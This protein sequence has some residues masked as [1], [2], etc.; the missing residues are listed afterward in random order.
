MRR[1]TTREIH[2]LLITIMDEIHRV[3]KKNSINYYM[4]YGTALG[5]ARV[6]GFIPWD[7]DMDLGMLRPDFEKFKRIFNEDSNVDKFFLQTYESDVDYVKPVMRVCLNG[8]YMPV[9]PHLSH[10]KMNK[11][12]YIDIFPLDNIADSEAER[13]KQVNKILRCK[14]I[15]KAQ[16]S[17]ISQNDSFFIKLKKRLSAFYYSNFYPQKK[18]YRSM[19]IEMQ[20]FNDSNTK[21]I[22]SLTLCYGEKR[23]TLKRYY[24]GKPTLRPFENREY[25]FPENMEDY[26][27][28]VYGKDY[29]KVPP[30][31]L[32]RKT[33]AVYAEDVL[34]PYVVGF[35]SI[36]INS[37]TAGMLSEL[38]SLSERCDHLYVGVKSSTKE[39]DNLMDTI[40]LTNNLSFVYKAVFQKGNDVM[41][42]WDRLHYQVLFLSEKDNLPSDMLDG[43]KGRSVKIENY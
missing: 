3:C 12:F 34:K 35:V 30:R 33:H 26:L 2:S 20:R 27:A 29:L 13:K 25:Y 4:L 6:Q 37:L 36:E 21:D 39:D 43:L 28:H 41:D 14:G 10:L 7:D 15:L 17:G 5:Q 19:D 11:S 16:N 8:T 1:L 38:K 18:V 31:T 24:L 42:V 9:Q 22:C 40:E 32:V 23:E